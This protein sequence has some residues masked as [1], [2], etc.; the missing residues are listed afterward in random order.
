MS[1]ATWWC[2]GALL[3]FLGKLADDPDMFRL[4][5]QTRGFQV[6]GLGLAW[7]VLCGGLWW[8][9][10]PWEVWAAWTVWATTEPPDAGA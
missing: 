7:A 5:D 6:V 10:L 8:L 4:V 3:T 1:F 9:L 2:L